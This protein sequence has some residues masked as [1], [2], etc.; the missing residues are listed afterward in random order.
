M[1]SA[2]TKLPASGPA[3]ETL[4]EKGQFWTPDWV[5]EAMVGYLLAGGCGEVFDPAVGMGAFFRAA[6]S[7]ERE[8]GKTIVLSGTEI[9]PHAL[10]LAS[11]NGLS[12]NDL[13]NVEI[14]DFVL[15]PPKGSFR[16]IVGNPPYIR[17]HRL[18]SEVKTELRAFGFRLVGKE[19]DGRAG[20][21]I[22]FLLRALQLLVKGG[23]LAFIVPADTCEGVFSSTLW[24]WI[25]K[26]Y[27]LEAVVTFASE[28]SPFPEVDTNPIIFMIKN[29]K[30]K[31]AFPWARCIK[32][33]TEE[34][35]KW[36]LSGFRAERLDDLQIYERRL[37]EGL[38]TGLSRSPLA[39]ESDGPTLSMFAA[40]LRGI[41]TGA[42]EFFFLTTRQ[43]KIL[44]IPGEFLVPAIGR[45]R[46]VMG[47][48]LTSETMHTLA[49]KGRPTVLFSPDGRPIEDF[50]PPVRKYLKRGEAMR[51]FER[52]LLAT[53]R[54][55]YKMEIR[56]VPP[57]LF[58]YLGRR[59]ARFIRNL[60][61][62]TPLTCLLCVYPHK[63]DPAYLDKLWQVLRHPETTAN[64]SLVGKSYG[65]GAIKVEPRALERLVLPAKVVEEIGLQ[66]PFKTERC[67]EPQSVPQQ[68]SLL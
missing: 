45:T 36:V 51:L 7:L 5:A 26:N 42:N 18:S 1:T 65:S 3:R 9:D 20:Y 35:K 53:R 56:R 54:P 58:A 46:D 31:D 38:T 21:H 16:G 13:A 28:A 57:I 43:A 12:Q 66:P 59:N 64:L 67:Q 19:L 62:V 52:P 10:E 34:L 23:R 27:R 63:E 17:H 30:P 24:E 50:P 48:E 11:Q 55:W 60:A 49:V 2:L 8:T 37:V 40:V 68:L 44:R 33:E 14:T 4:R 39:K 41:A 25:T 32:A 61:G 29:A 22:Y 47:E 15:Y 6:K